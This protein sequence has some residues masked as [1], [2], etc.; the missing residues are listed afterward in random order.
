MSNNLFDDSASKPLDITQ[1]TNNDILDNNSLSLFSD[2][3]SGLEQ[4]DPVPKP[5][6]STPTTVPTTAKVEPKSKPTP[7][8]ST[9]DMFS[10]RGDLLQSRYQNTRPGVVDINPDD[11]VNYFG[12]P[13]QV[14]ST[15]DKSVLDPSRA[16]L[17]TTSEQFKN[18]ATR[19]GKNVGMEMIA[20]LANIADVGDMWNADQEIGN[21]ITRKMR[22][23]QGE[24][25]EENPI[26]R[27]NPDKAL[28]WTDNG[29]L[30]DNAASLITSAGAFAGVGYLTGGLL[31]GLVGGGA[32]VLKAA[33]AIEAGVDTANAVQK[34]TSLANAVAL[35][36]AEGVD[37]G[38]DVFNNV[39][40]REL[41]K[42][43][44]E[45]EKSKLSDADIDK[46]A[47][48]RAADKASIA[49][50]LNWI[51]IATNYTSASA[52][53]KT[54]LGTRN[55]AKK[56]TFGTVAKEV[57]QEGT[58]ETFE[59]SVN[60]I[61]QKKGES[62]KAYSFKNAMSDLMTREGAESA[63]LGFIGG[64]GQTALTKAGKYLPIY[65]N[66]AYNNAYASEY[67]NPIYEGLSNEEKDAK[68]RAFALKKAGSDAG[69]VK[70][71][72]I[73]NRK[74]IEQ[75]EGLDN[76]KQNLDGKNKEFVDTFTSV[77][78][79]A[80]L[81][82]EVN[83]AK[84]AGDEVKAKALESRIF[85]N[86]A[87]DAF[88]RGTTDGFEEMYKGI[89]N[90]SHE[91]AKERGFY[92][93]GTE[94]TPNYY[95]TKARERQKDILELEKMF[96][97]TKKYINSNSVFGL[98]AQRYDNDKQLKRNMDKIAEL[99]DVIEKEHGY[100][101]NYTLG[102]DPNFKAPD[103]GITGS[104]YEGINKPKFEA[105]KSSKL[106]KEMKALMDA[107]DSLY[108]TNK[109]VRESLDVLTSTETQTKLSNSIKSLRRAREKKAEKEKVKTANKETKV[110][111]AKVINDLQT[112]VEA[113]KA[114][115]T[116]PVTPTNDTA[117]NPV[118]EP[119]ASPASVTPNAAVVPPPVSVNNSANVAQQ[120]NVTSK[121]TFATEPIDINIPQGL[122]TTQVTGIN[123]LMPTI[124]N[125]N[126]SLEKK[127]AAFEKMQADTR[128]AVETYKESFPVDAKKLEASN[129]LMDDFYTELLTLLNSQLQG[130]EQQ[131]D[132]LDETG[133]KLLETLQALQEAAN[134]VMGG[135]LNADAAIDAVNDPVVN[136]QFSD[137][138]TGM[139]NSGLDD[140]SIREV[141]LK[142]QESDKTLPI[143][144]YSYIATLH[145][146]LTGIPSEGTY[147]EVMLSEE[148]KQAL[149]DNHNLVT[150][151]K[152]TSDNYNPDIDDTTENESN[153]FSS[154]GIANANMNSASGKGVVN[155]DVLDT[156]VRRKFN[157]IGSNLLAYLARAYEEVFGKNFTDTN[158]YVEVTK[159]DI[160]N[161][162]INKKDQKVLDPDFLKVGD[163]IGFE[164]TSALM[165]DGVTVIPMDLTNVDNCP[166]AI[167]V[168]GIKVEGLYL[169]EPSWLSDKNLSGSPT[170]IANDQKELRRIRK[171]IL[172]NRG[173][174]ITTKITERTPGVLIKTVGGVF[175]TV[176]NA[177]PNVH[178][179]VVRNNRLEFGNQ[180]IENIPK[181]YKG[182]KLKE[183]SSVIVVPFGNT[184]LPVQTKRSKLSQEHIDSI[185]EAVDA[186]LTGKKTTL[187]NNM[188][189]T[190]KIDLLTTKGLETYI[191]MFLG[192]SKYD[193]S[194][195]DEL[196]SLLASSDTRS[197]ELLRVIQFSKGKLLYGRGLGAEVNEIYRS[198]LK[199][200][201]KEADLQHLREHLKGSYYHVDLGSLGSTVQV[202]VI[203]NGEI[204]IPF[205]TYDEFAKSIMLTQYM[206]MQI[207]TDNGK[208]DIYTIQGKIKY[209]TSIKHEEGGVT[210]VT[211][212]A[213]E[214]QPTNE[215][216]TTTQ[217][218]EE[219]RQR[220]EL[221]DYDEDTIYQNTQ[222]GNNPTTPFESMTAEEQIAFEKT[223]RDLS[224]RMASRI[225]MDYVIENKKGNKYKGKIENGK[226]YINLAYATLDTPIH[227]ILGHPIIRAIRGK[228][229]SSA[230]I[231][232]V[233]NR[234]QVKYIN[235]EGF[236]TSSEFFNT[237]EE[238][239]N[240]AKT[241]EVLGN[242]TLYQNLLKELEYGRGKEVLD[243]IKRDYV[244]KE[245]TYETSMYGQGSLIE[246]TKGNEVEISLEE[247]KRLPEGTV[248]DVES[249]EFLDR[250]TKTINI[251]GF[252]YKH[253]FGEDTRERVTKRE[254]PKY[255]LE[256][257]QEE[258]IVELL[259]MM[260]ADKLEAIKDKNIISLLRK[261]L[262]EVKM[263]MKSL[264]RQREVEVDKLP[265]SMSIGDL[266]DLLAYSNSKL[267]KPGYEVVYRTPDNNV[268]KT[269]EEASRHIS[270]LANSFENV[271]LDN[272]SMDLSEGI[273]NRIY[274]PV[275]NFI[276]DN[277]E[278]E[279]SKAIIEEWKSVNKIKYN[280]EEVYSRG[281]GFYS[282]VAAY[283]NFDVNL[284][285]QN[286]IQHLEHHKK[287]GADFMVSAFTDF[288]GEDEKKANINKRNI[289]TK[290]TFEIFPQSDDIK[291]AAPKDVVSGSVLNTHASFISNNVK[292]K[293]V[294]GV[295]QTKYPNSNYITDVSPNLAS[296]IDNIKHGHNELGIVLTGTNFRLKY[297]KGVPATTKKL[298]DNLNSIL[299]E[300]FGKIVKPEIKESNNDVK[301]VIYTPAIFGLVSNYFNTLEEALTAYSEFKKLQ[302]QATY[303]K[304]VKAGGIEPTQTKQTI[305]ESIGMV[306]NNF[307]RNEEETTLVS[308]KEF[309]NN[310]IG[311]I[312]EYKDKQ[313]RILSI[314]EYLDSEEYDYELIPLD[315]R[316]YTDQAL[317]NTKLAK[318]K[319]VAKKYPRALITAEVKSNSEAKYLKEKD[320]D[321]LP[322]QKIQ[323]FKE[324]VKVE[325]NAST[326]ETKRE[327]QSTFIKDTTQPIVKG[328]VINYKG[329]KYIV[330]NVN[331]SDK[332]QLIKA[333]GS[334]FS[335]TP[336]ITSPDVKSI[337]YYQIVV[338]PSTGGDVIVTDSGSIY[339]L[340]TGSRIHEAKDG[341]TTKKRTDIYNV[342]K[343]ELEV[344]IGKEKKVSSVKQPVQVPIAENKIEDSTAI[345]TR[346]FVK[347]NP[348]TLFVFGD[349]DARTGL[350]GQAKE[351]RGE[352]NAVGISTKK[353]PAKTDNAYKTDKELEKNK[354]S[355][356]ADVNSIIKE[357]RTG[358]YNKV[359]IPPLGVGLAELPTR[360]P[361]TYKF[362]LEELERLKR[363]VNAGP[364]AFPYMPVPKE[365]R[366]AIEQQ[367]AI[368]GK[369]AS[370][371]QEFDSLYETDDTVDNDELLATSL[372]LKGL[373][374]SLQSSIIQ[375]IAQ[376]AYADLDANRETPG[377]K[378]D[379][380]KFVKM[381]VKALNDLKEQHIKFQ[382]KMVDKVTD[383]VDAI[384]SQIPLL[385]SLVQDET[386]K[387]GNILE[388]ESELEEVDAEEAVSEDRVESSR[389]S[390]ND[391]A[392]FFIDPRT[393]LSSEIRNMLTGVKVVKMT[394]ENTYVPIS[395]ILKLNTY[396]PF[397]AIFNDLRNVLM[398]SNDNLGHYDSSIAN[399]T[400]WGEQ[401]DYMIHIFQ[402]LS[403]HIEGK[404][405]LL[406]IIE[407]LK[408]ADI[409]TQNKFANAFNV[410]H[411]NH[412]Y[413]QDIYD[414]TNNS[415]DCRVNS[416]SS[417]NITNLVLS[418][419]Q[420]GLRG[421]ALMLQT[422]SGLQVNPARLDRIL[423]NFNKI[424][425]EQ[426]EPSAEFLAS[427]FKLMGI[428]LPKEL[429]HDF[430]VNGIKV[431]PGV[432]HTVLESM[433]ISN[434]LLRNIAE[435]LAKHGTKTE[436]ALAVETFTLFDNSVF[437]E[438]AK[439]A[440]Y[441]RKDLFNNAFKNANGDTVF[442]VTGYRYVIEKM[443]DFK[444]NLGMVLALKNDVFSGSASWI[445]KILKTAV[446]GKQV[447]NKD[448]NFYKYF[449]YYTAESRKTKT[450]ELGKTVDKL[451]ASELARFHLTLFFNRGRTVG[452]G[453][454]KQHIQKI[455]YFTM[456]DK[457]NHVIMQIPSKIYKVGA[458][459]MTTEDKKEYVREIFLPEIRRI[460]A[461]QENGKFLNN[462]AYIKGGKYF[463]ISPLLHNV[464]SLWADK[465][466]TVLKSDVGTNPEYDEALE[467]VAY[468]IV[469]TAMEE[470]IA[471]WVKYGI[472]LEQVDETKYMQFIDTTYAQEFE[473]EGRKGVRDTA[474]HFIMSQA[475]AKMAMQQVIVGDPAF[476]TKFKS[477]N[478]FIRAREIMNNQ[479]KRLGLDNASHT[480]LL[481]NKGETFDLLVMEDDEYASNM[482]PYIKKMTS[483]ADVKKY[484]KITTTDALEFI[485][486]EEFL[487]WKLGEGSIN[488][489]QYEEIL[490]YYMKTGT[491]P[492]DY[493]KVVII[494][495]AKPV[496]NN[497]FMR[498]NTQTKLGIKSSALPILKSYTKGTQLEGLRKWMESPAGVHRAAFKSAVK[499]GA[500]IKSA[501]VFTNGNFSLPLDIEDSVIRG[502]PREGHGKQ[503]EVPYDAKSQIVNDG[504]QKSKLLFTDL[505][506]VMGF[507][508][509][510]T[511]EKVS[512][513]T[514]SESYLE[515]Y[516]RLFELKNK[517]LLKDLGYNPVTK[518]ITNYKKLHT[519]LVASA[520]SL[521][522]SSN[523]I[524]LLDLNEEGT[525]FA[526]P[527]WLN[528]SSTKIVALLNSL[529]DNSVRKR[530]FKGKSFVNS[531]SNGQIVEPGT[532]NKLG[533]TI[534]LNGHNGD[535]KNMY[536]DNGVMISAEI[537]IPFKFWDN[538]GNLLSIKDFVKTNE[539]GELVID[540]DKLPAD[541]LELNGYRIPTSGINLMSN[542]KIVG[543]LAEGQ[544]DTILASNDLI[545]QMGLDFDIDKLYTQLY[546]THYDGTTLTRITRET[547]ARYKN[548]KASEKVFRDRIKSIKGELRL[549]KESDV[550]RVLTK[551]F[552]ANYSKEGAVVD[553]EAIAENERAVEKMK[554]ITVL[555]KYLEDLRS[556]PLMK[557]YNIDE[558]ILQNELLD[559]NRAVL[560][561]PAK[562]VQ[563]ARMKRL[564]FGMLEYLAMLLEKTS[565]LES[566]NP[567]SDLYQRFKRIN[568]S[569]GK[570]AVSVFSL[571]NTFNSVL[572]Y[573]KEP[574]HLLEE[575]TDATGRKTLVPKRYNLFGQRSTALNS[576]ETANS[577]KS[578]VIYKSSV[579]SAFMAAALDNENEQLLGKLNI[580]EATFDAIRGLAQLGYTEDIICFILNQ[581]S[582]LE[583][584]ETTT[585]KRKPVPLTVFDSKMK[586]MLSIMSSAELQDLVDSKATD[587]DEQKAI[588]ALFQEMSAN[589]KKIKVLQSTLNVDSTGIGTNLFYTQ[590]KVEQLKALL[591]NNAISNTHLLL[592]NIVQADKEAEKR[593]VP[594]DEIREGLKDSGY[595]EMDTDLFVKPSNLGASAGFYA[596]FL[597]ND[598]WSN[599]FPYL[600][601][602]MRHRIESIVNK[603][604][605]T[606]T[607]INSIAAAKED[608]VNSFKSYLYSNSYG[609]FSKHGNIEE[610]RQ[611][612]LM[613]GENH[614]SLGSIVAL[615][616]EQNLYSNAFIS[617]L[618]T[619]NASSTVD[620]SGKIP[621]SL[622]YTSALS[623]ETSSELIIASII[624][625]IVN[626]VNIGTFND[627][628]LNSK[629]LARMLIQHQIITGGIQKSSQ[630]L[631]HIPHNYLEQLGFYESVEE[632]LN[633]ENTSSLDAK[634]LIQYVQHKPEEFYEEGIEKR[635]TVHG[636]TLFFNAKEEG[637]SRDFVVLKDGLIVQLFVKDSSD[638]FFRAD[639]LGN[640]G[641]TEY[642]FNSVGLARS[643]VFMN[644]EERRD[645]VTSEYLPTAN[646]VDNFLHIGR[647]VQD[648]E[649][650]AVYNAEEEGAT[651]QDKYHLTNESLP[652]ASK[653]GL[654][655][656]HIAIHTKSNT[657]SYFAEELQSLLHTLK[658]VNLIVDNSLPQKAV[659]RSYTQTR[660]AFEIR[661]N[662][663][664][665]RSENELQEILMEEILHAVLKSELANPESEF[666]LRL[667]QMRKD[668]LK[669]VVATH[670]QEVVDAVNNK[671][672]NKLPLK[673]DLERDIIY[674]LSNIDEFAAAAIKNKNFQKFLRNSE[675]VG[676]G[677][678]M[679]QRL[680]AF[681]T[682]A[683]VKMGL[684]KD[685]NL[686]RVISEVLG[687]VEDIKSKE[688]VVTDSKLIVPRYVR[689]VNYLNA[690]F[691]LTD[692]NSNLLIKGNSIDIANF[693]NA[694]IRNVLATEKDGTVLVE[695]KLVKGYIENANPDEAPNTTAGS[696][697][698]ENLIPYIS[699]LEFRIKRLQSNIKEAT[700]KNDLVKV[701]ELKEL[702]RKEKQNLEDVK[703]TPSLLALID[704]AKQDLQVVDEI[705]SRP[706]T[707]GDI[708]YVK[709]L[710]EFWKNAKDNVFLPADKLNQ[711]L[712]ERYGALESLASIR[713]DKLN[714][715][716]ES[717]TESFILNKL[718]KKATIAEIFAKYKDVSFFKKYMRDISN[719]GNTLLNAI[720]ASI[721]KAEMD[722]EREADE[723]LDGFDNLLEKAVVVLKTLGNKELFAPFIQ[724]TDNGT[725]ISNLVKPYTK[726]YYDE[727]IKARSR[728][729]EDSIDSFRGLVGWYFNNIVNT[730]L[731]RIFPKDGKV[732]KE[733]TAAR[734]ALKDTLNAG[735]FEVWFDSQQKLID[736]YNKD[737]E[738]YLSIVLA[739]NRVTKESE[740]VED[741]QGW[742][743]MQV[744]E[745][746]NSPY[747]LENMIFQ[748]VA[749]GTTTQNGFRSHKYYNSIPHNPT[750][751]D[752]NFNIIG[753][754]QD[755]FNLYKSI[756]DTFDDLAKF[757][758]LNQRKA[759]AYGGI[760]YIKKSILEMYSEQ[761]MAVGYRTAK[762]ILDKSV[763]TNFKGGNRIKTNPATGEQERD[764]SIPM[765]RD[766]YKEVQDY[767]KLKSAEYLIENK[768]SEVPPEFLIKWEEEKVQELTETQSFDLGKVM[769]VYMAAV[770]SH[771]H[772][773]R[774]ED[775]I[776]IAM[777]VI[778]S[779]EEIRTK[780]DGTP[781][782][783]ADNKQIALKSK[784]DSFPN[785]K[786]AVANYV[787]TT[788]YNEG[789]QEQGT[790]GTAKTAKEK[791]KEQ[792]IDSLLAQLEIALKDD[793]ITQN[794]Y[795]SVKAELELQKSEVG[796]T[797]V[798][799]K[800]VERGLDYFHVKLMAWNVIGA[801]GNLLTGYVSNA[802][803][804]AGGTQFTKAEL[805]QAMAML[806]SGERKKIRNIASRWK[807]I[808]NPN[809]E[810]DTD[811]TFS[812]YKFL[813]TYYL[814]SETEYINQ[815]PLVIAKL[816]HTKIM[817]AG[818]KEVPLYDALDEDGKWKPE[819]G[820]EPVQLLQST[821]LSVVQLI[822]RTHGN[823]DKL[824]PLLAK[825]TVGG[826]AL[827]MFRSWMLEGIAV[828]TEA[829]DI[830][831]ILGEVVKG[832]Y[833]SIGSLYTYKKDGSTL[834][835]TAEFGLNVLKG[836][837]RQSSGGYLFKDSGSFNNLVGADFSE[838]DASN[839]RK[840]C[841]EVSMLINVYIAVAMLTMIAGG[842]DDDEKEVLNLLINQ[843]L[844][845]NTDLS[846]YYNPLEARNL[847]KDIVP[848][849]ALVGDTINW[850]DALGKLL[851]GEDE[852]K[853][854]VHA[855]DSRF[856]NMTMKL[857]PGSSKYYAVQNSMSQIFKK[858]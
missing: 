663:S 356:T 751:K 94:N 536:D 194:T 155:F 567:H 280:P 121:K 347:A 125:L 834:V 285:M 622:T 126:I 257:Q 542:F 89:E 142:L 338:D 178:I 258:A 754:N 293:E 137:F 342:V 317:T 684:K 413:T 756:S 41:D 640:K 406:Q 192:Y 476:F 723:R 578:N 441:Y 838:L 313:F 673:A 670:G 464:E 282:V 726:A 513:R 850:V 26:Y 694:N 758:P 512:G 355:I 630:F 731:S 49:M 131:L 688:G 327:L 397:D 124:K 147:E 109:T 53:V 634:F 591:T 181:T 734:E 545:E 705:M 656:N 623:N 220:R 416:S 569:M 82:A 55:L 281:Q 352:P 241:F 768:A 793:T 38:V 708:Q 613:D 748:D 308:N 667:D 130:K 454:N 110:A 52:F 466:R 459:G 778:N 450:G 589:G 595:Y 84:A 88:T 158:S 658:D 732:T 25:N 321:E 488:T 587:T 564:G 766:N 435:H 492:K 554:M 610:V 265:D 378:I 90:L 182:F 77:E 777:D 436:N 470:Q 573:I 844:R 524:A 380:L 230:T 376:S 502:I 571:D 412:I 294:L 42:L 818:G 780:P 174:P 421:S 133:D 555:E 552:K 750:Y 715:I 826:K 516:R 46:E 683:L 272:I 707:S 653:F 374:P 451:N 303:P 490:N 504:T 468:E 453:A 788:L 208:K 236:I 849:M 47:K 354:A 769:K 115:V 85:Y 238:A 807:I 791:A 328:S 24:V 377:Y 73:T 433:T 474:Y 348:K 215:S 475:M 437:T 801:V 836:I 499:V 786:I 393:G 603:L 709:N 638:N 34:I 541:L 12:T 3:V 27:E 207:D 345:I 796:A 626:P 449:H 805:N 527:L 362:L 431:S 162:L 13:N 268:F 4:I 759:L 202:P 32:K 410:A 403:A 358:K 590:H 832:R 633:I 736:K 858:N 798:T 681:V 808:Q 811:T 266:A 144:F 134:A 686:T 277:N 566:F 772:K 501:K 820:E 718:G 335:G 444:S 657:I 693:I 481:H 343:A 713:V 662:M 296:I 592:G 727:L 651:L 204:T 407:K 728:V 156:S 209:A 547:V 505:L 196:K 273:D 430:T 579:T 692:K 848:A 316:W 332:L 680:V 817:D 175:N 179:A 233:G 854:G 246:T 370:L 636:N 176:L 847:A 462:G 746:R 290:I 678:N 700:S 80:N 654:I 96:I 549:T 83:L 765:I 644:Q 755:L 103:F 556:S 292:D 562:E 306:L 360:A 639:L 312:V 593:E 267:L 646:Q 575:S 61:A 221:E 62:E 484:S 577:T 649:S 631:K 456:A 320:D 664:K 669:Q 357:Y 446:D 560:A 269:Y 30:L 574:M 697:V 543:F 845:L 479:G 385:T 248:E 724:L 391:N 382:T 606:P 302:P 129:K 586:D 44:L 381:Q 722:A 783:D 679:W 8:E 782:I 647:K 227:E 841:K 508:D 113:N 561:N 200:A 279:K 189:S 170:S 95:K 43:K 507:I 776:K 168:N 522:Y 79:N 711:P 5:K 40:K 448:S 655:L 642:N 495:A 538:E 185:I 534:R 154:I 742:Y 389:S 548:L 298:I 198:K 581:P 264:L 528:H 141:I 822:K 15:T 54:P 503:Q 671:I 286:L 411:T 212:Q 461:I 324:F 857:L 643:V 31:G 394:L 598:L 304:E 652:N 68:A 493:L 526:N 674:N 104:V 33:G 702:L 366:K 510:E 171:I 67:S 291:W 6:A 276:K 117:V 36:H 28:D 568:A 35:N 802:I 341:S 190:H 14:G 239:E 690:K 565:N 399:D 737:R 744:W 792:E 56:V 146:K 160:D 326:D 842:D 585:I 157:E 779:Q 305:G 701:Q 353:L 785:V 278:F 21:A 676:T 520:K 812:K 570:T 206:A 331:A 602:A 518:E 480:P 351:M 87:E 426:K 344:E 803:E 419:W 75:E 387:L 515:K 197:G 659:T 237:K 118:V 729:K 615:I 594:I 69:L 71:K 92:I 339:S 249:D 153:L 486:A 580:N 186:H 106:G 827:L 287:V 243:R 463:I 775:D 310:K 219:D 139:R 452:K 473:I 420:S 760:P 691:N 329:E 741:E 804:A 609:I 445:N 367:S 78:E 70:D 814:S 226:A 161:F 100:R 790:M 386:T 439:R 500:P 274:N 825:K 607:S 813:N 188:M 213:E 16:R 614:L 677:K 824:S 438:L 457:I 583:Y 645:I 136:E 253:T 349:N 620:T 829:E 831:D 372:M 395:N 650:D 39:Y 423:T 244:D 752:A 301:Y 597:A 668:L 521:K 107:T 784:E 740:L 260:T 405:H 828:R 250:T 402:Q 37:I 553:P 150:G 442:G 558:L 311:D 469:K 672:A 496:Y 529:V 511:G 682:D 427:W 1:E 637:D 180:V 337:G 314:A 735:E 408:N 148:E 489:E 563:Q 270:K 833:R 687:V 761:G 114:A 460:Q 145:T 601:G 333:D 383:I 81:Q 739:R 122:T 455:A 2:G 819:F 252:I 396:I 48:T 487:K 256:E 477:S 440:S 429:V 183:G 745:E 525:D 18:A 699:S 618:Q 120:V 458:T 66:T 540:E 443:L 852:I 627:R 10:K 275:V 261:L 371:E 415:Y 262:K 58:Q 823:Y 641:M 414:N 11:Y 108:K 307:T 375:T 531:V 795:D 611:D 195:A 815:S 557:L 478:P 763:Q 135:N 259:G 695:S 45:Q 757:V 428:T 698:I 787:D 856:T 384:N 297:E 300:K 140:N 159:E 517:Q 418:E 72:F 539:N 363:E 417:K 612:L 747:I 704:T 172:D 635:V 725:L 247:F 91:E 764:S 22:E 846:F 203:K 359:V 289:G 648:T 187:T 254:L 228:D 774:V 730:N 319:Q 710:V 483:E 514:L 105:F 225:G 184:I 830:D 9:D 853:S 191:N 59:E 271:D 519:L 350:G 17:Q 550:Y 398:R 706:M 544:G 373:A 29:W 716:K 624:D 229:N 806:A 323:G 675:T 588:L 51:N 696:P 447:F 223:I 685:N 621:T 717:H 689:T 340:T 379:V 467:R 851:I 498:G 582:V 255:T 432:Y 128:K 797:R 112:K 843:G 434:G 346:P 369:K 424:V 336:N 201:T 794:V 506:D 263:F 628:S 743:E 86:Q 102:G 596:A 720:Y 767:I 205:E 712:T 50:K 19:V 472:V 7:Q 810:F 617:N 234:F 584:I 800:V 762:E 600:K 773:A 101:T 753:S 523:D 533:Q 625:M 64:A 608:V 210:E 98:E 494:Q 837:L 283:A 214:E 632:T 167:T 99:D 485:T 222:D 63:L 288:V 666:A 93:E 325:E 151:A 211:T 665:I 224:A 165:Q 152:K 57:A 835:N 404:P 164:P 299:D 173:E 619:G 771:K 491:F 123:K 111:N 235:N 330:W 770:M 409:S 576:I 401:P 318:L 816:L 719:Y 127:I 840:V 199:G 721:Q 76:Y 604:V 143:K 551:N 60:M 465:E 20:Q 809:S 738:A 400:T 616:K 119:T 322:F 163:V 535:L 295:S 368:T 138:L 482:M 546:N 388:A 177:M 789:T 599:M 218:S 364:T 799:S 425:E 703:T 839:M 497:T 365:K 537:I 530:K 315:K 390:F 855:G 242:N 116:P 629:D 149:I 232:I 251:N 781:L 284:M 193:A 471:E 821:R 23:L 392:D 532:P 714:L 65:K 605:P 132:Q 733:V 309:P 217:E 749:V 169:H 572:Q 97:A 166:I 661:I 422:K 240:Y 509:P 231:K 660:K 361:E 216:P 334:K 245:R 559:I 74:V